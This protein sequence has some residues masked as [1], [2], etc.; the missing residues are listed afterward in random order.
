M[1]IL[2]IDEA[3][4]GSII[5]N[6]IVAGAMFDEEGCLKLKELG[7][8]D[9]KLLSRKTRDRLY[10]EII[11]L[12]KGFQIISITPQEID[13]TLDSDSSNLNWLEAD[14]TIIIINKLKPDRA[15]I[16][17]PSPNIAKYKDYIQNRLDNP[18]IE[19]VVEHKA[20]L[21][22]SCCSAAS[23]LAKSTRDSNVDDIQ[24]ITGIDFGSGYPSDPKT[25]EFVKLNIDKFPDIFRKSWQTYKNIKNGK[26]QPTLSEF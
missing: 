14:K 22:H 18:A 11:K 2:G 16:D 12:A 17:C 15:I 3:G 23:I 26:N 21:N 20:D 6:L 8:K 5:G 25:I 9:S 10:H 19:L 1:N 13:T 7:A 24:K 4:R